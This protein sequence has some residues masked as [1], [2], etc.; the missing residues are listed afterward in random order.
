[1]AIFFENYDLDFFQEDEEL[2]RGL[3][4][5]CIQDGKILKGYSG[6]YVNHHLGDAQM[7]LRL[8]KREEKWEAIGIDTHSSGRCVWNVRIINT[9]PCE[10]GGP[11]E[12]RCLVKR[13]ED[14][15]GMAV[16]NIVN[17]DVLPSFAEEEEI[18]LQMIAASDCFHYHASEDGYNA[19][20]P[21]DNHGKTW[22]VAEGAV[23]PAGFLKNHSVD[24][25]TS[26]ADDE[27]DQ[28]VL[29]QAKV[30]ALYH[31]IIQ[32]GE[33]K[34]NR[35]IRCI[36]DTQFGELE[37]VHTYDQVPKEERE[38]IRVGATVSGVFRL[39]GDAAIYEYENGMVR[40]LENHLK[41]LRYCITGGDPERMRAV[42][43]EDAVY[44][45]ETLHKT[46][47]GP[48]D[49]IRHFVRVAEEGDSHYIVQM[50]TIVEHKEEDASMYPVGTRCAVL[51]QNQPDKYESIAFL[52]LDDDGNIKRLLIT[53]DSRYRFRVDPKPVEKEPDFELPKTMALSM[54]NRA[55][56]TGLLDWDITDPD[57]LVERFEE[58]GCFQ[59]VAKEKAAHLR[60]LPKDK[61]EDAFKK[62]LGEL[63][64]SSKVIPQ[65]MRRHM[66][67]NRRSRDILPEV[68]LIIRNLHH[69]SC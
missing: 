27:A 15:N 62:C 9:L 42:L 30:K 52:D 4:A 56:Y 60:A 46:T 6:A 19:S 67:T 58:T 40:D 36:M 3:W 61:F 59:K 37:F 25:E 12:K 69:P 50:A 10:G 63:F 2:M 57:D 7:I 54:A 29:L 1:M 66:L 5:M 17:A 64:E 48:D 38:N 49:I 53:A 22:G 18:R 68:R 13:A 47:C 35:F 55:V 32:L 14:G 16:I 26:E 21:K 43:A 51:S 23:F 11:F 34:H 8:R 45:S 39:S 65:C 24:Q 31:G 28:Y 41:L 44:Q 33:E 20:L